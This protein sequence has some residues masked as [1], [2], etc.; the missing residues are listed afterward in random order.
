[1]TGFREMF[2]SWLAATLTAGTLISPLPAAMAQDS[3]DTVNSL[4]F[5]LMTPQEHAA[6]NA[7]ERTRILEQ[8]KR[9]QD[10]QQRPALL[11]QQLN[12]VREFYTELEAALGI[13]ASLQSRLLQLLAE[14]RLA[15]ELRSAEERLA[16][17]E[18]NYPNPRA[19]EKATVARFDR[20]RGAI[21]AL[22][23]PVAFRRYL[24]YLDTLIERREVA[25]LDGTLGGLRLRSDQKER[26]I[27]LLAAQRREY[28]ERTLSSPTGTMQ[29]EMF[30]PMYN[31]GP[32]SLQRAN[33]LANVRLTETV[34]EVE[35]Q[36][37]QQLL[38]ATAKF[39]SSSQQAALASRDAKNLAARRQQL[40][41]LRGQAGLAADQ[42]LDEVY[43]RVGMPP[44]VVAQPMKWTLRISVNQREQRV[45]FNTQSGEPVTFEAAEGLSMDAV[46]TA[47]DNGRM[48]VQ[49]AIYEQD[50][51]GRY[52]I[53]DLEGSGPL[54]GGADGGP[55]VGTAPV[56][57]GVF[58]DTTSNGAFNVNATMST[59]STI[60]AGSK[61][62][63]LSISPYGALQ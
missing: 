53:G 2:P 39:L 54:N 55:N 44:Q 51:A 49:L 3:G 52:R 59:S 1:M 35:T 57:T 30:S 50:E 5:K 9:A 42:P 32:G 19:A 7:S 17:I 31:G 26:L 33:V 63:A 56:I 12:N 29:Q 4:E 34:L 60:L 47:Y 16:M 23:G 18:G 40:R 14:Q 25:Y 46:A 62:Y 15:E 27:A 58:S 45:N 28:R 22:L 24:G 11:E 43:P 20:D 48:R 41:S 10:P 13:D 8:I 6:R 21:K 38:Q 61:G 37:S 36:Q